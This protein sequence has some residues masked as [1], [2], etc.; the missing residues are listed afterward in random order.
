MAVIIFMPDGVVAYVRKWAFRQEGASFSS[1]SG[2]GEAQT[3]ERPC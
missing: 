1:S 3:G 2:E